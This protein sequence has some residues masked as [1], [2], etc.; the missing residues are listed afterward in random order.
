MATRRVGQR[1]LWCLVVLAQ[2]LHLN[3]HIY[4]TGN[5][6]VRVRECEVDSPCGARG[7]CRQH[8]Y[9]NSRVELRAPGRR[10]GR[11]RFEKHRCLVGSQHGFLLSNSSAG[12]DGGD[13][14]V[15]GRLPGNLKCGVW[16]L[17]DD[18][19]VKSTDCSSRVSSSIPSAQMAAH[20]WM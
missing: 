4:E 5:P 6:G 10:K 9:C 3:G 7:E 1:K 14:P 20:N 2:L 12:G 17:R 19:T 13:F 15:S 11:F 16:G 8:M 18:S